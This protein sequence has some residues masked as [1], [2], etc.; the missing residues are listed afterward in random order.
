MLDA[1]LRSTLEN[2]LYEAAKVAGIVK[3]D[4]RY[5]RPDNSYTLKDGRKFVREYTAHYLTNV[6][7]QDLTDAIREERS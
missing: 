7:P 5:N 2:K 1:L 3:P 6:H 4:V